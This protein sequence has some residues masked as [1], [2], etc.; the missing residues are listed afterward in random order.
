[1]QKSSAGINIW[2]S[3]SIKPALD[4]RT[5]TVWYPEFESS[6]KES[7]G[8]LSHDYLSDSKWRHPF[9]TD[10]E[11]KWKIILLLD[12]VE[13][14]MELQVPHVLHTANFFNG[15]Q[16]TAEGTPDKKDV[17]LLCPFERGQRLNKV[18]VIFLAYL[19]SGQMWMQPYSG[20]TSVLQ[21]PA[22]K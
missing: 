17:D 16:E 9:L 14:T 8:C 11:W 4:T 21:V 19:H 2:P 5:Q 18:I 3:V 1:M 20:Y 12:I 10:C 15:L 22:R 13:D 7:F 6:V